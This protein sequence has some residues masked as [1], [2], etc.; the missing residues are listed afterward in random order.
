[1][2]NSETKQK[3]N[4]LRDTLVGVVPMPQTQVEQITLALIY[5]F[6]SDIDDETSGI[7]TDASFF[8]W[9]YAQYKWTA[10]MDSKLSAQDRLNLY[11]EGMES[12]KTNPKIPQL[13]RNIYKHAF[14]PFR[15]PTTLDR[16][17]KQINDFHYEHSEDLGDAFEYLLSCLSAAGDAGMFRTPRHIIDFIVAVVQPKNTDKI[18]DPA[19]GTAWFLISAYKYITQHQKWEDINMENLSKQIIWYDISPNMVQLALVNLYLHQFP[20][21]QIEEYDTLTSDVHWWEKFDCILANPPFMTPKGGI[22][23]HNKFGVSSNRS[24]VL[25]VDYIMEHLKSTGKAGIIVPEGVIFKSANAYKALRKSLIEDG[26][27]WAVVSLPA[28]VFNP[29]SW[30]KTSIL[31]L[32]KNLKTDNIYFGKISADGYDLWAQRREISKNDLPELLA[33]LIEIKNNLTSW[34]S[35]IYM[36]DLVWSVPKP[37]IATDYNLSAERYKTGAVAHTGS[38]DMVELGEVCD[39]FNWATPKKT[40]IE[41]RENWSIPRFTIDDIRKQWRII[42][43]TQQSI[44]ELWFKESSVKLLPKHATLLCCTASLWE[45]AFTEIELT[46]N[47]QFNWIVVNKDNQEKIHPKFLYW[48]IT[49]F[50]EELEKMSWKSTFWFVSVSTLKTFKIPLPPLYIQEQIVK[51]LDGYQ[52][53]IDGARQ[54][55]NNRKPKIEIDLEREMV[56]LGDVSETSSWWTPLKSKDEYYNWWTIPRLR[57]WEVAQGFITESELF[58]SE[59]WLKS[60]SA[61]L[62]PINTVLVAMY[63]ATAWQVWILKF[64]STTNQA[65][66]WIFPNDKFIPEFLY[67]ALKD[68]KEYM[69]TLAWWWAQPN[70]S[71]TIIRDLK[72]PLP[73]LDIQQSIV[74]RIQNEQSLVDSARELVKIYEEKIKD[75]IE[76]VWMG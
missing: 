55:V 1:M 72:I 19:C 30:V 44:S 26:W 76:K 53:I 23:P 10:L 3:I 48:C 43:K 40:I 8:P 42:S 5:K 63:W 41:Y 59:A 4:N 60:S 20:N 50:K 46:T 52:A 75:R 25:F 69:I 38:W 24:E 62:F 31:L 34:S 73:P 27:L 22:A 61:K 51:E 15:N 18:L 32:D 11:T 21:P 39:I 57:S 35:D 6:M 71:Q 12:M 68:Q 14:L 28:W 17:L 37:D 56:K 64:E 9:E 70:I 74:T 16:F 2:L 65:V 67:Q 47:Q 45:Y 49:T 66:C 33:S 54:I 29:Y 13:F 58:I 7:F 36:S